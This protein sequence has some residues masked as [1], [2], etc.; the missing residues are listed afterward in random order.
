MAAA[1]YYQK[2]RITKHNTTKNTAAAGCFW[3]FRITKKQHN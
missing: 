3:K 1:G 2:P